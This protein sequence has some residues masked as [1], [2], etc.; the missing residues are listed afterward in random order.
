[1]CDSALTMDELVHSRPSQAERFRGRVKMGQQQTTS[2]VFREQ[3]GESRIERPVSVA[4]TG[5]LSIKG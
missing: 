1:M 3:R 4:P 5:T 2:N